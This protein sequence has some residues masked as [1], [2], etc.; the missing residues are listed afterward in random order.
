L[1]LLAI[2]AELMI[3]TDFEDVIEP[4]WAA[5]PGIFFGPFVK[6]RFN[7]QIIQLTLLNIFF[8]KLERNTPCASESSFV[9]IRIQNT[10]QLS[11]PS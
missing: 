2:E 6:F 9:S 11:R 1:S 5:R 8:S 3:D 4:A 10:T 7:I